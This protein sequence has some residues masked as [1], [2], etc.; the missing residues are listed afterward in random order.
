MLICETFER[1][2]IANE[3]PDT[4]EARGQHKL[5]TSLVWLKLHLFEK[6][7]Q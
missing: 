6:P 1:L 3:N 5:S 7:Q 4:S 2:E